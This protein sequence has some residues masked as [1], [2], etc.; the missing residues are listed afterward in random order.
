MTDIL[1]PDEMYELLP[2]CWCAACCTF[3]SPQSNVVCG[4]CWH[5]FGTE[6]NLVRV[7]NLW[8]DIRPATTAAEVFSCPICTHDL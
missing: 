3:E 8:P 2:D 6:A 1:T 5:D 4:E 7:H